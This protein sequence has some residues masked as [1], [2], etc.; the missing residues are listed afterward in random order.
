MIKVDSSLS[1]FK[2]T[3]KHKFAEPSPFSAEEAPAH[4]AYRYRK[5]KLDEKNTLILRTELDAI[6]KVGNANANIS[7]KTV[8]EYDPKVPIYYDLY[9]LCFAGVI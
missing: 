4:K 3:E 5:F 7:L 6:T 1:V 8:M 2:A 9:L